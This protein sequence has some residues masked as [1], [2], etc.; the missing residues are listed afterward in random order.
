MDIMAQLELYFEK[1]LLT[2]LHLQVSAKKPWENKDLFLDMIRT[3]LDENNHSLLKRQ[4]QKISNVGIE[5]IKAT[6][7]GFIVNLEDFYS[8]FAANDFNMG[9]NSQEQKYNESALLKL[10]ITLTDCSKRVKL[11]RERAEKIL[12][13]NKRAL[14]SSI[15]C[16]CEKYNIEE[17]LITVYLIAYRMT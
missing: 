16:E 5:H 2:I 17:L 14:E 13:C 11:K 6:E 15:R 12:L 9:S 10:N 3:L 8:T 4:L 7:K 1:A